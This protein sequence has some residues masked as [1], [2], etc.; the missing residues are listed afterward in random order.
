MCLSL[1]APLVLS[2]IGAGTANEVT[3]LHRLASC[4]ATKWD[5]A[6]AIWKADYQLP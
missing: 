3:V 2:V 5:H 4:L 1:L 6:V